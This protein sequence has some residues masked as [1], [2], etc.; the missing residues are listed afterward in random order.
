VSVSAAF[1][2]IDEASSDRPFVI[3]QLGQ[4]LDGRIATLTGHSRYINRNAALDHLHKIRA[5][6]D[7]VIVGIGT[8][9]ADDPLLNV[10]RVIGENPARVVIDP[11]G[12]MPL[13]SRLLYEDGARRI[14]IRGK[15]SPL[16]NGVEEVI[17]P[18][19]N[20]MI[21]PNFIINALFSLGLAKFL[22]EGGAKTI[23]Q[24][25][26]HNAVDRL[27]V[28]V[29]PMIIGSGKP[30]IELPPIS[31]VDDALRPLTEVTILS[32]GDVLFDCNLRSLTKGV[33]D[34]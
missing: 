1:A 8:V 16:P 6:V 20:G 11:S 25:I 17:L 2:H 27:H 14:I 29:A 12:R 22:V 26:S 9:I 4:S 13:S 10:R 33:S 18:V 30:G 21:N 24:F 5:H 31:V 7:A 32:D 28:L 19:E 23:S 3:A 15:S 34:V